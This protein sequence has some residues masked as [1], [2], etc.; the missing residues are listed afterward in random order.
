MYFLNLT[1]IVHLYVTYTVLQMDYVEGF[2]MLI[3]F[4]KNGFWIE[5]LSIRRRKAFSLK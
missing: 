2:N 5:K 3:R 4:Q 1:F